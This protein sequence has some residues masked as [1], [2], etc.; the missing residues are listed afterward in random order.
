MLKSSLPLYLSEALNFDWI[1][2]EACGG[3]LRMSQVSPL[4]SLHFVPIPISIE[5]S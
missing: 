2:L 4:R 1:F 5:F 3:G